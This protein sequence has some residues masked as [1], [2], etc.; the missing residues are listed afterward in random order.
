MSCPKRLH[1]LSPRVS[2]VFIAALVLAALYGVCAANATLPPWLQHVVGASTAESALYRVMHLP[3]ADT[4]Y[5]RPPKEAQAELARQISGQ[6]DPDLYA[7]RAHADEQALDEPTAEADWKL[8]AARKNTPEAQLSLAD[9]YQRR[10]QAAPEVEVLKQVAAA[11]TPASEQYL[12]PDAQLAWKTYLRLLA[13]VTDQAAPTP[14]I[15]QIYE[16]FELRYP[17]Q[18]AVYAHE[19]QFLVDARLFAPAEAVVSRYRTRLPHDSIFPVRAEAQIALAQSGPTQALAVYDRSFEPLWPAPLVAGYFD[20]LAQT[21]QQRAYVAR[22]RAALTAQPQ[23]PAA[24]AALARIFYYDQQAGRT[25]Q[26]RRTLEAFRVAREAAGSPW[27]AEDLST[28][29]AL[30]ALTA[31][32][33]EEARYNFALASTP[34]NLATGEPAAQAGLAALVHLLLTAS[35]TDSAQPLALGAGNLSLYRDIATLDQGP[36]YWNGILSLWLNGTDPATEYNSENDKAQTYFHRAKAADLLAQLDSRFPAAPQ[37]AALHA[38]LLAAVAQYGEPA[39]VISEGKQFL[40]AFPRAPQRVDVASLMADAYARQNDTAAEFALYDSLLTELSAQTAGQPLTAADLAADAS[41]PVPSVDADSDSSTPAPPKAT[42]SL[43]AL[44]PPTRLSLPAAGQYKRIL[45]RY[46]ARLVETQQ[47]PQALTLLRRQLDRNPDDPL[48]YERLATF[49]EQNNLSA[50]QEAVFTQAIQKFQQP[51]W[52]DKLARLYLRERKRQAFAT[53][54]H[55]VVDIFS[56]TE[57]DAYFRTVTPSAAPTEPGPQLALQLNLYAQKRF[58]HDLVFTQ[59]LL[60]AYSTKPTANAAAYEALL[61]RQWY[62]SDALRDQFFAFLSRTGKLDAELAG[63]TAAPPTD[64]NPAAL[65]ELA[66]LE[67]WTSHFEQAVTPTSTLATL[68]P[69]DPTLDDQAVSLFRSFSYLDPTSASLDRAVLI[70]QN[71]LRAE[72]DSPDRLA[73]LGDLYA[74]ATAD[75]GEDL[76]SAAPFWHRIPPLHPGTPAGFLTSATIFWDYFQF[77]AALAELDAARTRFTAPTLFGYEAGAIEENRHNLA[78]AVRDYTAIVVTPPPQTFFFT[79]LDATLEAFFKP[80]SDAADSNLQATAQ[81]LFNSAD[82]RTRL[83]QLA[84]R[85]ATAKLVDQAAADAVAASP[86]TTALTL[87]ADVLLAQH[88]SAEL[89]ALLTAALARARTA[90]EAAAIGDLARPQSAAG[91]DPAHMQEVDVALPVQGSSTAQVTRIY[92]PAE[93]YALAQVYEASLA[94][95][96][97]LTADPVEKIQLQYALA[98]SLESR[99]QIAAAQAVIVSVYTANPRV[100]GV[101][102][103]TVGFYARTHQPAQAIATLL[104][105][106]QAATPQLAHDFTLE[107]ATRANDS[108]NPAQARQLALTLLPQNPYDPQVLAVIAASY[109]RQNDNAGLKAFYLAQLEAARTAPDLSRDDRKADIALLRRGLIPALTSLHDNSGALDQYIALLSAYPEDSATAQ[110]AAVFAI[111]YKLQPQLVHFLE[112]TVQQSPRDS[113]FAILLAQV[114]TTFED[115]PAALRAY[116]L[117]IAIRKDR[118]DLF[119]ARATLE[120]ALGQASSSDA[121]SA[122]AEAML[123]RAAADYARLYVLTY[124]DPQWQVRLAELRARQSRPAEAVAAL[125]T[126]YIDGHPTTGPIAAAN[127]FTVADQLVAWNLLSEARGFA[128]QGAHLAGPD[129]LATSATGPAIYARIFTRLGRPAD[130]LS[131]LVASRAGAL[132]ATPTLKALQAA[133]A[134][135]AASSADS[136]ADDAADA[137]APSP[138]DLAALRAN[139]LATRR[140]TIET[141]FNAAIDAIGSTVQQYF[142]PEQKAAFGVTADALHGSNP[143]IAVRVAASSGLAAREALWRQQQLLAAAAGAP[144][145]STQVAAYVS[146]QQHR[147]AFAELA[148]T[149]EAYAARVRRE[150]RDG[151]STQASEAFR[152]AGDT[153]GELRVDRGSALASSPRLRDR[154]LDLLLAHD[155]AALDALA[156]STDASLADTAVNYTLAHGTFEQTAAVLSARGKSLEPVW[157]DA[158]LALAGLYLDTGT[159]AAGP[160][161][162]GAF[163]RV[164]R[165][166]FTIADH[167][168]HPADPKRSLAGDLWF[169]EARSFGVLLSMPVQA[170]AGAASSAAYEPEDFLPAGLEAS[171]SDAAAYLDLARTYAES[172]SPPTAFDRARAEYAHVLELAPTGALAVTV[173]ADQALLLDRTGQRAAAIAEWRVA[174]DLLRQ[175]GDEAYGESFFTGYRSVL[176]QIAA[177]HI[178][179]GDAIAGVLGP[180]LARNGNYRSNEMLHAAYDASPTPAGGLALILSVANSATN[181]S[182]ILRDLGTADWLPPPARK[183]VLERSLTSGDQEARYTVREQLIALDLETRD[184]AALRALLDSVPATEQTRTSTLFVKAQLLL[185]A[186]QGSLPAALDAAAIRL[187]DSAGSV[188]SADFAPYTQAAAALS[189]A[190]ATPADAANA[191]LLRQFVF[192]QKQLAHGLLPVDFLSLAQARLATGDLPGALALLRRLTLQPP[193][194]ATGDTAASGASENL[195]AAASLLLAAHH[196][197]EAIPFLRALVAQTP[198]SA[199][200]KLHLAEAE[201]TA[202]G[203][204]QGDAMAALVAV[205]KDSNAA[206][207]LRIEAARQLRLVSPPEL[208]SAELNLLAHPAVTPAQARQPG[209]VAAR[210]AVAGASGTPPADRI[211][212][213]REALAAS[214]LGLAADRARLDLFLAQTQPLVP[215]R[216]AAQP[217]DTLALLQLLA[218]STVSTGSTVA[219]ENPAGASANGSAESGSV[220]EADDAPADASQPGTTEPAASEPAASPDSSAAAA[221]LPPLALTFDVPTKARLAELYASAYFSLHEHAQAIAYLQLALRLE[222]TPAARQLLAGVRAAAA[223]DRLNRSRR[224]VFA[225]GLTQKID[226]RPRLSLA[227]ATRLAYVGDPR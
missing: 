183:A 143:A 40:A 139:L 86:G 49:L 205:A 131:A 87:R 164:L 203:T 182:Q 3:G 81:S 221:T 8:Y 121:D 93:S 175:Q 27:S 217:P 129:F 7:Q 111:R 109:A 90:D 133:A 61:R 171:P 13:L 105:A 157:T 186:H 122:A 222:P 21:H 23:G 97:A 44:Y 1:S 161:A 113:R 6:P 197:A 140:Q 126:A 125:R 48:L 145:D 41:A 170:S 88:R 78:A 64:S 106:A 95:Q 38:E 25:T 190:G 60:T 134:T 68:Y 179:L 168:S 147:L 76:A 204:A 206:Y 160:A 213:L 110:Q 224:P 158:N 135:S 26:A 155:P 43:T 152:A 124:H 211:L 32:S 39:A 4:L 19:V 101:V 180:Y 214:P 188:G 207:D 72:P 82:A 96:V 192:D 199:T 63:L 89:P 166:D 173:H 20:L 177:R 141:N 16:A 47:L 167:L 149:L 33:G 104:A 116:D 195:D 163:T 144:A 148:Q 209:F 54:T 83:L 107:A 10:L 108:G 37:R 45:D 128:Q 73:T 99:K 227:D 92:A 28:L 130:A 74:E 102:R 11:P 169:R 194:A 59:N 118:A 71:L 80:P 24:L 210:L 159:S 57:L 30:A 112:T 154:Y 208:G 202:A 77:D 66:G 100:L 46:L 117:A 137:D 9:F 62:A 184:D 201:L 223:L 69:A 65:R 142:T 198:W 193:A 200:Y 218:G 79:S 162:S 51:T 36:G 50:Q 84:R 226:V 196:A 55:K 176:Q 187:A 103:A 146:L 52:Y 172:S 2:P 220:A 94:R 178:D 165:A 53:L 91:G 17:L 35:A 34:G 174:L 29:A 14:E 189:V 115:F 56:G 5:P 18:P 132:A 138:A 212:L 153:A 156:A 191:L 181:P 136:D 31:D 70:E 215:A 98:T 150:D 216:P 22:A 58:P 127:A 119:E 225:A 114:Q 185:A 151:I 42:A 120:L 219:S 123:D 12:R 75:A 85:P 15:A 67:V